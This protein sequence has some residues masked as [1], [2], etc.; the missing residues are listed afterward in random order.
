MLLVLTE[1]A[2]HRR[3][4]F[5]ENGEADLSYA[6]PGVARFR[7]NI[8]RERG[9]TAMTLRNIPQEVPELTKLG[10][11]TVIGSMALESHGLVLVTGATGSGKT[12][13][14]AAM[15]DH[16][17]R[18]KQAH[19]LTI[20]DPIEIVHPNHKSL[21]SQREVGMDTAD[22]KQ[23]LRRAL[24]QDP[25][26]ILIGEIRD[27]ET[28]RTALA[29][30]ETGHLVL[31]TLHTI[32]AQETIA[33]VL[34]LFPAD[35]EKQARAMLAGALQGIISQRLARTTDGGRV[36]VVE[37]LVNTARIADCILNPEE[38][39]KI[40]EAIERGEYYGMQ[41]FDQCLI[42]LI[43]EGKVAE[44]EAMHHVSSPQNFKLMLESTRAQYGMDGRVFGQPTPAPEVVVAADPILDAAAVA[45]TPEP[46]PVS[47]AAE[48]TPAPLPGT[49]SPSAVPVPGAAAP[50]AAQAHPVPAA[51]APVQMEAHH[52][53][54]PV[55]VANPE[56]APVAPP[57]ALPADADPLAGAPSAIP[58]VPMPAPEHPAFVPTAAPQPTPPQA[59][60]A[61]LHAMAPIP[62]PS[63]APTPPPP[64]PMSQEPQLAAPPAQPAQP[65]HDPV[66]ASAPAAASALP[67]P[68]APPPQ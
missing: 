8:F 28:M 12:T 37:V 17:N 46:A 9:N 11:P 41:T 3:Q 52:V 68:P 36:A 18:T 45:I 10:V 30:A 42:G 14:L 66:A 67:G 51:E 39:G 20:E 5:K 2:P 47:P 62:I 19:I 24:R 57:A 31:A 29:A 58:V 43:A 21:I 44:D 48:M 23:A 33:R 13:T 15:I 64:A 34:D 63:A 16:I 49:P 7:V 40:T 1:R 65:V 32:N 35:A 4:E 25:D 38:T 60:P 27:E 53:P 59:A 50:P 26:V 61:D 55:P 6:L 22:F 56:Q 54:T